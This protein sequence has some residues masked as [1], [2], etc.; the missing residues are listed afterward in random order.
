MGKIVSTGMINATI[1]GIKVNTSKKAH[2]SNYGNN[3]SRTVNYIVMHY[4][5]NVKDAASANANY[6]Q[7]ANRQASAHFFVDNTSIYQSVELRDTAW[8]CGGYSYY[9]K[10]CRNSNAFGIEMCCTAGNYKVSD[11]TIK[12]SAHLCAYL[13]K[14][15]GI[16][17]K[18]VDTYVLR[19]YDITHKKCPAQMA[20]SASD[21]DWIAFK[22]QVKALLGGS[23]TAATTAPKEVYRVR[24]AWDKPDTQIGAYSTLTNAKSACDKAGKGYSVFNNAGKVVYPE[25]TAIDSFKVKINCDVLNVRADAT[26]TAKINTQVKKG[27]IYTI[28]AKKDGWG[29]LKSG[30][31][32]IKLS[33]TVKL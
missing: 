12:N 9:H 13:C 4:T 19:H 24:K 7:G 31:G 3:S 21:P 11:K 28:V 5:G 25:A 26:T 27:E 16:S 22:K 6:F 20:N 17:A 30:A 32:W 33:Y 2:S 23:T 15:L 18:E 29:K 10:Y 14:M 8:H 1:N